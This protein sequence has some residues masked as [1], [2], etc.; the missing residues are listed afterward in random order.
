MKD[1]IKHIFKK[2][3]IY[4]IFAI[5][6]FLNIFCFPD[7]LNHKDIKLNDLSWTVHHSAEILPIATQDKEAL[8]IIDIAEVIIFKI[9]NF[10]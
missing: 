3:I 7:L 10:V 2:N 6:I 5:F 4:I 9:E 1:N 8:P